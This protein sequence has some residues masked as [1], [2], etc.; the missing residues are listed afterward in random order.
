MRWAILVLLA[1]HFIPVQ[2]QVWTGIFII[3]ATCSPSFCCCSSNSIAFS[4]PSS[5]VLSFNTSL[6]GNLCQGLTSYASQA[7][8]PTG[9]T[10]SFT[11]SIITLTISLSND[12]N[13]LT[14]TSSLGASCGVVGFRQNSIVQTTTITTTTTG[15]GNIAAKEYANTLMLFVLAFLCIVFSF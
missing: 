6:A 10:V 4:R 9:Y 11:I 8:Y 5:T 3:N 14:M 12:S 2:C 1:T 13:I 15:H 7:T